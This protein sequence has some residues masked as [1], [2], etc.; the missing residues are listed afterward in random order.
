MTDSEHLYAEAVNRALDGTG[1]ILTDNDHRQIMGSSIDFTWQWVMKRFCLGYDIHYW[2]RKYDPAV[3]ELLGAEALPMPGLLALLDALEAREVKIG[4]ATS[5]MG[6]WAQAV[7]SKLGI[8]ERFESVASC[9][10]VENAKPAPDLYLLAAK[11]LGVSP[12]A[13]LAIEDSPRGIQ[14]AAGAG[15]RVIGL[16]NAAVETDELSFADYV[17]GSL[18]EFD[19]EWLK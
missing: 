19:F 15:M 9:E 1:N 16:K 10:M 18:P 14:A 8:T 2:K 13:C 5:S 4:L 11:R 7:L 12:K 6:H 17:I 3:I